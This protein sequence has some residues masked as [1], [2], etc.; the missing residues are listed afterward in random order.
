MLIDLASTGAP[1]PEVFF[2]SNAALV[3]S[4]V[5]HDGRVGLA[6]ERHA[7]NTLAALHAHSAPTFGY[8]YET[9]IGGLAQVNHP[10]SS[11]RR[12]FAEH[13]LVAMAEL[14]AGR[15][16][17]SPEDA[18]RV[19]RVASRLPEWIDEPAAPALVHGDLWS[20]NVLFEDGRLVGLIDPAI[21]F[22]DAE[23]EL[24]FITLFSTFSQ[25]FFDAY[26]AV[27]PI[28]DNFWAVKRELY[29][30]Y[31]LLVHVA[32]FGGGYVRQAMEHV[33]RFE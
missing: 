5:P 4:F 16:K 13:R 18:R 19:E 24:A 6:G 29:N 10:D 15:G 21:Y 20:G 14:A 8:A 27:R 28:S 25:E 9:R 23:V 31:P 12:F 17:L 30:V 22:A 2:V 11:W 33:R 3:M 1:V 26:A 32:L 7:A